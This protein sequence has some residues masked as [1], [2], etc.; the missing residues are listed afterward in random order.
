MLHQLH[1]L[2]ALQ[3]WMPY[4]KSLITSAYTKLDDAT[5]AFLLSEYEQEVVNHDGSCFVIGRSGKSYE[6][7]QPFL[8]DRH[9]DECFSAGTGK[10]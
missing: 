7:Q 1:D 6:S 8:H 4:S 3:K 5:H 9:A 10:T 2:L